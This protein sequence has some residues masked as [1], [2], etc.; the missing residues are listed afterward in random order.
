MKLLQLLLV[1]KLLRF[2]N[3]PLLGLDLLRSCLLELDLFLQFLLLFFDFYKLFISLFDAVVGLD[4]YFLDFGS[5]FI[6]FDEAI[7]GG[8][9]LHQGSC[10]L[11][12][13]LL[14]VLFCIFEFVLSV[15]ILLPQSLDFN[16]QF[17]VMFC[18]IGM[19]LLYIWA[20][21]LMLVSNLFRFDNIV[22][23]GIFESS[24]I[25]DELVDVLLTTGVVSTT[26]LALQL[27]TLIEELFVADLQVA[28]QLF[29]MLG[30]LRE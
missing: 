2:Y 19:F 5:L 6:L 15:P 25:T 30:L 11:A 26:V 16:F 17:P 14:V 12:A 4:S 27:F 10:E 23:V 29:E 13:V 1:G 9:I 28:M 22:S 7:P 20:F 8:L 18:N 24:D 21:P 3:L